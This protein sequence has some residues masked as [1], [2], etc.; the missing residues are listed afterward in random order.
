MDINYFP[1]NNFVHNVSRETLK[2]NIYLC[3]IFFKYLNLLAYV[4][5]DKTFGSINTKSLYNK[6][7]LFV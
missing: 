4:L 7:K 1:G 6:T 5:I 3:L 2:K